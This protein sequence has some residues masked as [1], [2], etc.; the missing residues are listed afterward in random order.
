MDAICS[1][2]CTVRLLLSFI[3]GRHT[4]TCVWVCVC[5]NCPCVHVFGICVYVCIYI[6]IVKIASIK[7]THSHTK[8]CKLL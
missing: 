6:N 4:E 1:F 2:V 8:E 5:A 3:I 7:P